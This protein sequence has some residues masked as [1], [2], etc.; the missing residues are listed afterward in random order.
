MR[1]WKAPQGGS[2]IVL[3]PQRR[4]LG[5]GPSCSRPYHTLSR[6][7][8]YLIFY[9]TDR[10]LLAA[11]PGGKVSVH[12]R[13]IHGLA[14]G[15]RRGQATEPCHSG[16]PRGRADLADPQVRNE[17]SRGATFSGEDREWSSV[18]RSF[19]PKGRFG[20]SRSYRPRAWCVARTCSRCPLRGWSRKASTSLSPS[21]PYH[22]VWP[23]AWRRR[24]PD[25]ARLAESW[26][27]G[28]PVGSDD[29]GAGGLLTVGG[30]STEPV[31]ELDAR[32]VFLSLQ[33]R[34]HSSDC[35]G[36]TNIEISWLDPRSA[37]GRTLS[38]G[39]G[40][41]AGQHTGRENESLDDARTR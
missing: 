30:A 39:G 15:H 26:A 6:R 5:A 7:R 19:A 4:R 24:P 35:R 29:R 14:I 32:V 20:I 8:R 41:G 2:E 16:P 13:A 25:C 40:K 37:R 23:A 22:S 28:Q 33:A 1:S 31:A 11:S 17:A 36:V 34:A 12:H 10:L 9:R 21:A 38:W 18:S 27:R 3:T